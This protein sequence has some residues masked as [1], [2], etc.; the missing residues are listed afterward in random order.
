MLSLAEFIESRR[1]TVI[2]REQQKI[3]DEIVKIRDKAAK[4]MHEYR[5]L[6]TVM[7]NLKTYNAL[8]T[9]PDQDYA[10]KFLDQVVDDMRGLTRS[11]QRVVQ[12]IIDSMKD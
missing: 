9:A 3:E 1:G 12:K 6:M 7:S 2:T 11:N 10:Q 4:Q 8:R 5:A